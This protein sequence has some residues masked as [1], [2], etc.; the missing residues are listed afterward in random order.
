MEHFKLNLESNFKFDDI[1]V[2]L[3]NFDGFH[4]GHQKLITELNNVKLKKDYKSA[5]FLFESHTKDLIFHQNS[6][7][8]MSFEDKLKKLE[9]FK[10]DYVF[11]IE[12][13][14][15][16]KNLT[17]KEFLDFLTINLN[18]KHIVVGKDYRFSKNRE[19][20]TDFIKSYMEEKCLSC[21]IVD[22]LNYDD[23]EISST[24]IIEY[25]KSGKIELANDLLGY[26][27]SIKGK[28]THGFQRGRNL[29]YPTANIEMSFN[30]VMVKEGVYFTKTIVDGKGYFS[31][32]SVGYNPT[33]DNKKSTIESH[34]F[35]FYEDIYGKNIELCFLKRLRDN[36]KFNSINELIE[37]L[38]KDE[39][40]CRE[41]IKNI[42]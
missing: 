23:I 40:K 33:F 8:I 25:I 35:N 22:K 39:I 42:K 7:R 36:I 5:V 16:I 29:G 6:S 3:G 4:L 21:T 19:G 30:Y 12:F 31:F 37:Q 27:F 26:N 9:S 13:S 10:I 34:I 15:K 1:V 28:V 20:N 14:E 24:K 11:S 38:K 17:P 18:I 32:S 41:L 2:A